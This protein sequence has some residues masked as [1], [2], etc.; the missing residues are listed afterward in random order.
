[1]KP[2]SAL[3]GQVLVVAAELDPH[4][5]ATQFIVEGVSVVGGCVA[6]RARPTP[7]CMALAEE[8]CGAT[9]HVRSAANEDRQKS[10]PNRGKSDRRNVATA[11]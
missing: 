10:K 4:P 7:G 2:E 11:R 1:M 5:P 9:A 6:Q 8:R 3:R